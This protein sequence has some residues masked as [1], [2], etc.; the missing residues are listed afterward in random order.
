VAVTVSNNCSS[1]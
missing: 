1:E